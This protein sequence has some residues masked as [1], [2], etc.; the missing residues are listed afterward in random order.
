MKDVDIRLATDSDLADVVAMIVESHK[1]EYFAAFG[2][3]DPKAVAESLAPII[4]E[5]KLLIAINGKGPIG[6]C[7]FTTAPLWFNNDYT[8]AS[9]AAWWV[10]PS[11]RRDGVGTE[12]LRK[13]EQEA[14]KY[15]AKSLFVTARRD[16]EMAVG[17]IL[18]MGYR[19]AQAQYVKGL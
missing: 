3:T 15:G 2:E 10:R 9:T 18:G 6:L 19:L 5:K 12:L 4:G 14:V 8:I 17:K 1:D 13:A 16:S 7:G 11:K